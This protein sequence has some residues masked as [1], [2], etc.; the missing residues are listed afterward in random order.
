MASKIQILFLS[1]TTVRKITFHFVESQKNTPEQKILLFYIVEKS[2]NQSSH[3]KGIST[4][5]KHFRED[6]SHLWPFYCSQK[7]PE[8]NLDFSFGHEG[9]LTLAQH[10]VLYFG[11]F[12]LTK[13]QRATNLH[14]VWQCQVPSGTRDKLPTLHSSCKSVSTMAKYPRQHWPRMWLQGNHIELSSFKSYQ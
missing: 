5:L 8:K 7:F 14:K 3:M 1:E 11:L 12:F 4:A 6:S 9:P 2:M 10:C 13:V